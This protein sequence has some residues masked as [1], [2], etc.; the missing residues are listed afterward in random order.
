LPSARWA[1]SGGTSTA[2]T[3][4]LSTCRPST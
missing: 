1:A 3:Q 4:P 2:S